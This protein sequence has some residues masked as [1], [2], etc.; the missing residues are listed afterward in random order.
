M[1]E[2]LQSR[3]VCPRDK[4]PL[5]F[6]ENRLTCPRGHV[7][8]VFE[9]IPVMLVDDAEITHDYINRTLEKIAGA[10]SAP[11]ENQNPPNGSDK[12]EIDA[13]VQGEVPYTSGNLYFS[14]QH[15]LTRYPIPE[16]RLPVGRG[17]RLLDIGCN[18]GRWSI[19]AARKGYRPIGLDPSLDAV[20][21]ARR[22]SRQLGIETDFL[23]GD[24]R[25]LPFADDSF[26][27][28]FSYGVFQHFSKENVRTSLDEVVRVLKPNGKTLFQMP[29][30]YG[31]RQYQQHR[32]RG[33]TEGEGFEVRYWTP[34]ELIETFERRFGATEMTTDCYF[35]LGIQASDVD[36]LPLHYKMV[37]YSS[38][39]LRKIS[40]VIKPLT[41][42]ADSVYLESEN[43]KKSETK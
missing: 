32:R 21:A 4:E 11:A 31:I 3:L 27:A 23:V 24:A 18:W 40:G 34:A 13:F 37:V 30:K 29:N 7:Y 35:G 19:A 22:V 42:V 25:F 2:W 6:S 38:E 33:F 1:N 36:L 17:E 41:K 9:D 5:K 14:V 20:L 39:L 28:V 15:K 10:R 8:P 43:R 16:C 12:N 26:D